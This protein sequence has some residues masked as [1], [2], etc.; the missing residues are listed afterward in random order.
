MSTNISSTLNQLGS[1]GTS[2]LDSTKTTSSNPSTENS[3]SENKIDFEELLRTSND[4]IQKDRAS[5]SKNNGSVFSGDETQEE[6][7]SKLSGYGKP[8]RQDPKNV[9]NKD[10]F[11]K[12]FITQL[13]N[14]DPLKPEDSA[15]MSA[16]LAQFNSLEQMMDMNTSLDKLI[17][18]QSGNT[19]KDLINYIGKEV[20]LSEGL[21]SVDASTNASSPQHIRFSLPQDAASCS[22][23]ITDDTG[24]VVVSKDLGTCVKGAHSFDWDG[25]LENNQKAPDGKYSYNIK[26]SDINGTNIA[27]DI[28]TTVKITGVDIKDSSSP[29]IS[30]VGKLKLEDISSVED[31]SYKKESPTAAPTNNQV[32]RPISTQSTTST[33]RPSSESTAKVSG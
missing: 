15:E 16:R 22:I 14:Q 9:L 10:D 19:S 20:K 26:A 5:S 3:S 13:S 1:L 8:K 12:L 11:L 30:S 18:M 25:L 4:Q 24:K 6:F 27:A 28:D 21:L 23:N 29:F 17:Q 32:P 7:L 33:S 2:S 31:T